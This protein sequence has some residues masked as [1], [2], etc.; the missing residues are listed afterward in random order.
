MHKRHARWAAAVFAVVMVLAAG[1]ALAENS[2]GGGSGLSVVQAIVFGIV[3]GLTEYL[4]VSSTGHLLVAKEIMR[5]G[6]SG[7]FDAAINAYIV[8]IQ[9]GAIL[10]I[11]V[12]CLNRFISLYRWGRLRR[13][14]SRQ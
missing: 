6:G 1:A 11:L 7:E 5:A 2:S 12:I 3:E 10:A 4:P 14:R 9:F 13:K 8:V